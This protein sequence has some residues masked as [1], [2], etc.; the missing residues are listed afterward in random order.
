MKTSD[1]TSKKMHHI[2]R[3]G[4]I[5]LIAILIATPIQLTQVY[6]EDSQHTLEETEQFEDSTQ[7]IVN[8]ETDHTELEDQ[9]DPVSNDQE[10]SDHSQTSTKE[11]SFEDYVKQATEKEQHPNM[12][13]ASSERVTNPELD[14]NDSSLPS[15]DVIDVA[16]YQS[17]MT[18]ADFNAVKSQGVKTV[19][20]KLTEGTGYVN[21]YAK[22]Q[23]T[24]AK[25]AGLNVAAYHFPT[26]SAEQSDQ[27]VANQAARNE[28]DYF[29]NVAKSLNLPTSTVMVFDAEDHPKT[30]VGA[31]ID[32][33]DASLNFAN[34]MKLNGYSNTKYYC[35]LSWTTMANKI[36]PSV[37]GYK[38]IW[39]AQYLLNKPDGSNPKHTNYGAWQYTDKMKYS[40]MSKVG[41]IDTSVDYSNFFN[42]P[43]YGNKPEPDAVVLSINSHMENVGWLYGGTQNQTIGTTGQ[44]R[45]LE[46]LTIDIPGFSDNINIKSHIQNIGWTSP[47]SGGDTTGTTG[48]FL[49]MEAISI[50]LTGDLAARYDIYYRAHIQ[51]HGWLGWAKN[52]ANAGSEGKS[53]RMEAIQIQLVEKGGPA[54]GSTANAFIK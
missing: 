32:W 33:T 36:N 18:Q 19:V 41:Y 1:N 48:R 3:I 40:S 45:R 43:N 38:N 12:M 37:L 26:L 42:D 10:S 24:Y 21:P 11:L 5:L 47:V 44:S 27:N 39:I 35:S 31:S 23:I 17:W 49:R 8:E 25:N 4:T 46:A 13:G 34:Q 53:L 9:A 16:S 22:Q 29:S 14:S 28:A 50:D 51:N 30:P 6:A 2:G 20:V 54:P 52:G 7:E 15:R